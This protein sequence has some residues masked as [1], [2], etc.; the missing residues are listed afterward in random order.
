[1]VITFFRG[2][3]R[4]VANGL[5]G[6]MAKQPRPQNSC[7]KNRVKLRLEELEDRLLPSASVFTDLSFYLLPGGFAQPVH[8]TTAG[9]QLGEVVRFQVLHTD[10]T[11]NTGAG[12]T[13]FF[14]KDGGPGDLDGKVNGSIQ[15]DWSIPTDDSAGSQFAV[16]AF[17]EF[18]N[19]SAQTAFSVSNFNL[20]TRDSIVA[21]PGGNP[22]ATEC[23]TQLQSDATVPFGFI[24]FFPKGI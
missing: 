19:F 20:S 2:L 8:I 6:G 9:F 1:M 23:V 14:I 17:G 7:P 12:H 3:F 10:G 13:A 21:S 4:R 16:T 5:P 18:S 22:S 11:P 15:T 24:N